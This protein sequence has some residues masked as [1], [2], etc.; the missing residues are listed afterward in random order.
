[1]KLLVA[2]EWVA[3]YFDTP[4]DLRTVRGWVE[5]G[6]VPGRVLGKL[7]YI[8]DEAWKA[9]VRTGDALADKALNKLNS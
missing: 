9:S 3:K 2:S 7:T 6:E 1:M 4:P 5:R 8:D